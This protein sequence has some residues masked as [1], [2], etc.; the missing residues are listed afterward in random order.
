[1]V[2]R[3]KGEVLLETTDGSFVLRFDFNALCEIE[4]AL[5]K[6]IG[7]VLADL[8]R[9]SAL[10]TRAMVWAAIRAGGKTDVSLEEAGRLISGIKLPAL[11]GTVERA[12]Q[13]AFPEDDGEGTSENP[14]PAANAGTGTP[15]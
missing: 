13:A 4:S 12:F 10:S 5:R 6:P 7:D 8:R 3:E 15:S 1:M 14:Q 2:N 9:F 11:V